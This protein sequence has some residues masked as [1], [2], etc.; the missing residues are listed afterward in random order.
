MKNKE[1]LMFIILFLGMYLFPYIPLELF[2]INY[3]NLTSN[4]KIIYNFLCDLGYIIIIFMIYYKD[5]INDFKKYISNFKKIISL[6]FKYYSIGL[7]FMIATNIIIGVFFSNA[8]ANNEI[9]VR[10]MIDI[11]PLY[12]IFSTSIYA[13]IVEEMIFRKSIK[14]MFLV[15]KDNKI[16]NYSYILISGFVFALMHILGNTTSYLDYIYIIPYMAVGM[17]FA[18][19]YYECD[20]IFSVITLHSLHNTVTILLYLVLGVR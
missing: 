7:F 18:K 8:S 2:N 1:I 5:I 9:A 15:G 10:R 6:A 14:D 11:Y 17:S 4:M 20:N 12:M 13:P 16:I 19:V 3:N